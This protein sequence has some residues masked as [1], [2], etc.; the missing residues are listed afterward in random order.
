MDAEGL[1]NRTKEFAHRC[2]KLSLALPEGFLGNHIRRQ[3][4]R[5]ATSVASNY[6]ATCLAQS[7][8]TFLSKLS[9]V[10]EEADESIFWMEFLVDEHQLEKHLVDPLLEEARELAAIF[11]AARKTA[12]NRASE[13]EGKDQ[14]DNNK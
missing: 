14:S 2:V 5:C 11:V 3:L 9:I 10:L 13:F 8:A 4:I 1:K 7:R 12:R 6:R